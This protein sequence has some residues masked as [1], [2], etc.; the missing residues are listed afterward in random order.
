MN[1]ELYLPTGKEKDYLPYFDYVKDE[2]LEG[3]AYFIKEVKI[4]PLSSLWE[5]TI[6]RAEEQYN[7]VSSD[8]RRTFELM[9]LKFEYSLN[10]DQTNSYKLILDE[11]AKK[12]VSKAYLNIAIVEGNLEELVISTMFGIYGNANV[13]DMMDEEGKK[14][15]KMLIDKKLIKRRVKKLS[16]MPNIDDEDF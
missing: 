11:N 7:N 8:W 9:G 12:Y 5:E 15:L 6:R 3:Y 10:E 2:K 4:D 16:P 14:F 13:V 1:V